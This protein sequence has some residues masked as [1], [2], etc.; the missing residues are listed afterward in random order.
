MKIIDLEQGS[1]EWIEWRSSGIGAS[2][3]SVLTGS[4]MYSTPLKLW[5][6]KC[7]YREEEPINIAMAHGIAN[8]D[9]ARQ[10]MNNYFKL[11][12]KPLCI[13]D[14]SKSHY[15]A[16]LDGYDAST[17]T[18]VEIKCPISPRI[19]ANARTHN[20]VPGYWHDQMQWQIMLCQPKR[21]ILAL[22][23]PDNQCCIT[24]EMF[25]ITETIEMMQQMSDK[26]WNQVQM[27]KE[28]DATDADFVQI[29][30][31]ALQEALLEYQNI[32]QKEKIGSD[33][34][35][36]LKK[37]IEG[38]ANEQSIQAYGFKVKKMA[39]RNT[40]DLERMREDGIE[41]DNYLKK[42]SSFSYRITS[43]K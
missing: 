17:E 19:L 23:D 5:E 43:P 34:K 15:K 2:D 24:I 32:T 7:G 16:S 14:S 27:G 30:D 18:L 37:V 31:P 40:Y 20:A 33:R 29:T 42:G 12:L 22:W 9:V 39:P 10:W 1:A 35:K 11:N 13:E 38:F 21:A 3:V 26:F 28:P 4:N 36:E 41:V 6:K 8:E 25:A